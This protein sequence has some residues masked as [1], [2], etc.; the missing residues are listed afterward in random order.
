MSYYISYKLESD[1][2][3]A[4][5]ED[6]RNKIGFMITATEGE[7]YKVVKRTDTTTIL[8]KEENGCIAR[9]TFTIKEDE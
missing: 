4:D 2:I 1:C 6:A 3:V 7:G 5:Y 9:R 8:E